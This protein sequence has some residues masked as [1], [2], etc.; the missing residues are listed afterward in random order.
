M[1][2][3]VL[4]IGLLA[5]LIV[6]LNSC[7]KDSG[8][9]DGEECDITV[10]SL[11][12]KYRLVSAKYISGGQE[13]DAMNNMYEPC[14]RD[15]INELKADGTFNYIDAGTVCSPSN[16]TSGT[17]NVSGQTLTLNG[18]FSVIETFNC[19]QMVVTF[20]EDNSARTVREVY[21]KLP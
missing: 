6:G 13:T 20:Q 19:R 2:N 10:A 8:D 18:G 16:S 9:D 15:D 11:A 1:R 3:I 7:K 14:E 12:G 4:N 5:F 21:E 17:W